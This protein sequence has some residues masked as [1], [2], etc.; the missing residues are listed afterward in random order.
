MRRLTLWLLLALLTVVVAGG[1]FA[2]G[3]RE[4]ET[5]S[6]TVIMP[7]IAVSRGYPELVPEYEAKT[8]VKVDLIVMPEA[9]YEQQVMLELGRRGSGYDVVW[10]GLAAA[11]KY[12]A[13]GWIEPLDGY[14]NDPQFTDPVEFDFDDF[15]QGPVGMFTFD[16]T[17]YGL[18]AMNAT[19]LMYYRKDVFAEH[20]IES[21]PETWAELMEV[22]ETIH[23]ADMAAI[24]MRGSR[25][26]YGVMWPFPMI[27]HS[28]G[29][30]FVV[31]YPRDMRPVVDS[32]EMIQAAEYY[33]KLL[34]DY[35]FSGATTGHWSEVV[36]AY[37]QGHAAIAIDGA[38]LV[39]TL[40]DPEE[41]VAAGKTGFAPVPRGPAAHWPPANGHALTIP[42]GSRNKAVAWDFIKWALSK[43]TQLE[44]GLRN[45][46]TALTRVSVINDPSYQE[47]FDY[48][49]GEYL[50]ALNKTFDVL[51]PYYWPIV[52]E[53]REAEDYISVALSEILTG[54]KDAETALGEAQ[55]AMYEVFQEAGYY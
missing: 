45:T 13:E 19:V 21:P 6:I 22:A 44:N 43:E 40:L 53:W 26:R 20:G 33:A 34:R 35:G 41:S 47:K 55:R 24:A 16:D 7:R 12:A 9:E 42:V 36:V 10:A 54:I 18:P 27:A 32:P 46:E 3:A 5:D 38:P 23:S 39:G 2:A 29:A 37:Q 30:K 31:D 15:L 17:I 52:P 25:S 28:F 11:Q 48:G 14:I 1:A 50:E 8:G 49:D 4:A 51:K